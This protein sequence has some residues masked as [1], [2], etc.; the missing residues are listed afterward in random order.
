MH[1]APLLMLGALCLASAVGCHSQHDARYREAARVTHGDPHRGRRT[2][3][4]YGCQN[5]HTIPGIR[6]AHALV[7][8]P[9][10]QVASRA[11]LAG[12][13]PNTPE[14]MMQWI[15][16]P[17]HVEQHTVMPE[18]GVTLDDSRDI[19]AYLYTLR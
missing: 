6:E 18:M 4:K 16:H 1:K 8:P 13:L 14:N 12:E 9:L 3:L 11:Y 15:Q 7:G 5:C 10:G 17:H 2:I 19:T